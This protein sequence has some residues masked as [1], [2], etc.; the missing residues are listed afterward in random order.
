MYAANLP[1]QQRC[2]TAA[3]HAN[4][5]HGGDNRRNIRDFGHPQGGPQEPQ[6]RGGEDSTALST[7]Q[8]AHASTTP[9]PLT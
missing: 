1:P 8:I 4:R 9:H 7:T 2:A 3:Q 5:N 6:D